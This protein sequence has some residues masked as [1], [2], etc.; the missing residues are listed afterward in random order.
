MTARD[1]IQLSGLD[2]TYRQRLALSPFNASGGESSGIY[3]NTTSTS[4]G[5]GGL[6]TIETGELSLRD[7][8]QLSASSQGTEAAG[9]LDNSDIVARATQG[10]GGRI[11]I[12]SSA[13]FGI[14]PRL[15][16]TSNSDINASSDLGVLMATTPLA[17]LTSIQTMDSSSCPQTPPIQLMSVAARS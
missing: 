11:N 16:L 2:P 1:R 9:G 10:E 17:R 8:A 3:A 12:E 13:L 14:A 5:T 7:T 15:E 6:V 4:S